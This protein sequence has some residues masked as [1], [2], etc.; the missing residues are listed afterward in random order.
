MFTE[1]TY[2]GGI[3]QILWGF[4]PP[5]PP[6]LRAR[7]TKLFATLQIHTVEGGWQK[8]LSEVFDF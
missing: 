5:P 2:F 4:V 1:S 7:V 3:R 8:A 6:A